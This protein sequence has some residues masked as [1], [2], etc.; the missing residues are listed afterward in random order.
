MNFICLINQI[1]SLKLFCLER[2]RCYKTRG[3]WCKQIHHL[4]KK[5]NKKTSAIFLTFRQCVPK[6]D[7]RRLICNF[8][9]GGRF[10][11][12]S[13]ISWLIGGATQPA[14]AR[15]RAMASTSL[16]G[17]K[18]QIKKGEV[19]ATDSDS[20]KKIWEKQWRE[21]RCAR[22]QA[23]SLCRLQSDKKRKS[24]QR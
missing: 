23:S 12:G 9:E 19:M 15:G 13:I 10:P 22:V 1:P 16:C 7:L 20:G 3:W 2:G 5:L 11:S 14:A 18:S 24:M 21:Q 8:L 17:E 4:T 6:P